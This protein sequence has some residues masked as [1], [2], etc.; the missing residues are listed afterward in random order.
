MLA[1]I[2]QLGFSTK[3]KTTRSKAKTL[4]WIGLIVA[5]VCASTSTTYAKMLTA[6]LSPL[7]LLFLSESIVLLFTAMSF[8]IV[9]IIEDLFK[10]GKKLVAPLLVVGIANS[11]IAPMLVFTG[12]HMSKAINAEL[13]LR[14]YGIFLFIFASIFLREK[15]HRTDIFGLLCTTAGIVVVALKGFST[16]FGVESGDMLI[17]AGALTYAV[18]GVI[19]KKRLRKLHP[20][21]ILF[22]RGAIAVTFFII[23]SPFL[24]H[25]LVGELKAFPM[26]LL[27]ALIGYGFISRFLYLFSFY[28]AVEKLPIHTVSMVLPL[29]T[30]GSLAFAH[31]TLGETL[32]WYHILGGTLIILGSL[33]VQLSAKHFR[34]KH[35]SWHLRHSNR[36]HL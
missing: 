16:G 29:I 26:T 11:V 1:P 36:H 33:V 21:I 23:I 25:N 18:G 6:S 13:Y 3:T 30:V 20:E 8:G 24:E 10:H 12:L 5:I 28:E 32:L 17:L 19:F 34:G 31:V 4:G 7:S 2:L 15:I 22:V 14:T 9:P 27:S 35:L